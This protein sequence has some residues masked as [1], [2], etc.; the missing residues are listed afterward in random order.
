MANWDA[1]MASTIPAAITAAASIYVA[2]K[3]WKKDIP[4]A[5][6]VDIQPQKAKRFSLSW[7]WALVISPLISCYQVYASARF[8]YVN[9]SSKEPVTHPTVLLFAFHVAMILFNILFQ[10]ILALFIFSANVYHKALSAKLMADKIIDHINEDNRAQ[11]E[12]YERLLSKT[13]TPD[14]NKIEH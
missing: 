12:M 9:A 7:N 1:L 8:L 10:C 3:T 14:S 4:T 11:S 6:A 2:S 5:N 13:V